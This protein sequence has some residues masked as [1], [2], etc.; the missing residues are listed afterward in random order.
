MLGRAERDGKAREL[1]KIREWNQKVQFKGR[2][3]F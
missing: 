3:E 1:Q 2:S